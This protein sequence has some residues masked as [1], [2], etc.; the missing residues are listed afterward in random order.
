MNRKFLAIEISLTSLVVV[1]LLVIIVPK[2]M[3]SEIEDKVPKTYSD[4]RALSS[5]IRLYFL[6]HHELPDKL[7]ELHNK[8]NPNE[9]QYIENE[10][11]Q[12]LKSI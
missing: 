2:V 7:E 1:I 11:L 5:A 3:N 4:I 9:I 12:Y 6:N 8:D 10:T